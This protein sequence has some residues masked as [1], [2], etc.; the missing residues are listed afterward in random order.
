[1]LVCNADGRILTF[2]DDSFVGQPMG[3]V[4]AVTPEELSPGIHFCQD[5]TQTQYSRYW[6]RRTAKAGPNPFFLTDILLKRYI[7]FPENKCFFRYLVIFNT[8]FVEFLGCLERFDPKCHFFNKITQKFRE[9]EYFFGH[10]EIFFENM[11][12]LD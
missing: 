3:A 8:I 5:T 1:M 10:L 6:L 11:S 12:V 7:K 4:S 9:I 2:V